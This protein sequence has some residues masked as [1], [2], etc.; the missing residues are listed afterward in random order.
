MGV[1]VVA[2][3]VVDAVVVAITVFILVVL[4]DVPAGVRVVVEAINPE[5]VDRISVVPLVLGALG[6]IVDV[7][8]TEELLVLQTAQT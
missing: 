6:L 2:G 5:T 7:V 1:I 8:V 4:A 3:F